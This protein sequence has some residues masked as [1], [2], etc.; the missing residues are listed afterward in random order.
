M[1]TAHLLGGF[2]IS[3]PK[4]RDVSPRSRKARGLLGY[5][6]LSDL[7]TERREK[8]AGLLWSESPIDQA[9]GSLRHCI[10]E[11]RRLG[12]AAGIAFLDADRQNVRIDRA[13]I[14][15]DITDLKASLAAARIADCRHILS[16]PDLTLMPGVEADDPTFDN[17]LLV[18][19]ERNAESL[20]QEM[21]A[22]LQRPGI[23]P[24]DRVDLA[25]AIERLDPYQE[26]AVRIHMEQLAAEGNIAAATAYY[27]RYR[28]RLLREY[29]VEPSEELVDFA[30][31]LAT[32]VSS[33]ARKPKTAAARPAA[34]QGPSSHRGVPVIAVLWLPGTS[35]SEELR[36]VVD[37]FAHALISTL[38]R[39][40][41]WTVIAAT[42]SVQAKTMKSTES[43]LDE[44]AERGVDYAL[45]TSISSVAGASAINVR[46]L[47]CDNRAVLISDQYPASSENWLATLNDICCRIASRT[48]ISLTAARLRRSSGNSVEQKQAYDLWLEGEVLSRL[49]ERETQDK[50]VDLFSRALQLDPSL[51]SAYGAW[52]AVLNSRWIVFPGLPSEERDREQAYQL[53]KRAVALDPLNSRNQ[54]DLGFS[55]LLAR[56]FDPA[57]L[58][59]GLAYDLNPSNPDNVLACALANAFCGNH[60]RARELRARAFDLNPF[61][62]P[63]YH[64]YWASIDFLARDFVGCIDAVNRAPDVFPDIQAW[65][66]SA[67]AHLGDLDSARAALD[68]FFVD[69]RKH[70]A[71]PPK[72]SE[73]MLVDWFVNIFPLRKDAD[74]RLLADGL[75]KI[76]TAPRQGKRR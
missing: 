36:Q 76:A 42:E 10:G 46:L 7:G 24:R 25:R 34:V 72:P 49:F 50:A 74:R 40:K 15:C 60:P 70:W 63:F 64:G 14:K 6:L 5:L 66:A 73:A 22:L 3:D 17:W 1:L 56:R 67:H 4:G 45:L 30:E 37:A 44:L 53:A 59:F 33:T 62:Q 13:R 52:A 55:H 35:M 39:F 75:S 43:A 27:E 16:G 8:L 9:Y 19:R 18:E 23:E 71:G 48:Q 51:S 61:P 2:S 11:L 12:Q 68:R 58:H 28:A 54:V 20:V 21:L 31:E 41:D 65:A 38:C 47:E 69:V 32:R 29:E 26:D 57:E